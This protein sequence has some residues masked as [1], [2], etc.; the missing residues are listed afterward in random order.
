[1]TFD[2]D[3]SAEGVAARV[4]ARENAASAAAGSEL[5]AAL[6]QILDRGTLSRSE[7]FASLLQRST[8]ASLARRYSDVPD[9]GVR[10]A[11]FYVLAGAMMPAVLFEASFISS[12]AG[13]LRLNMPDYREKLADGIVNA[14]RAYQAGK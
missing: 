1:M 9:L 5:A 8:M 11:G 6:S 3:Q 7:H 2:L 4:A 14:V 13:E 12:P 10:R